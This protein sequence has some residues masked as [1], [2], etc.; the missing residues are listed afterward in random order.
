MW[1]FIAIGLEYIKVGI[2]LIELLLLPQL[3]G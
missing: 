3:N 1:V 2:C